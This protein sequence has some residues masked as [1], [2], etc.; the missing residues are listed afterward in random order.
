MS[1]E[2][3]TI[4]FRMYYVDALRDLDARAFADR[5]SGRALPD[6]A[7][8]EECS[9][10]CGPRHMLDRD[11]TLDNIACG[12]VIRL[13]FVTVVRK[14][15]ESLLLAECKMEEQ[16]TM[17]ASGLQVLPRVARAEIRQRV[18]ERLLPQTQAALSAI[19][20]WI[21]PAKGVMFAETTT[22]A[23][24]DTLCCAFKDAFGC[25]PIMVTPETAA[26]RMSGV[27]ANDLFPA[28]YSPDPAKDH[29]VEVFLGMEFLTW[30][31]WNYDQTGGAFTTRLHGPQLGYMLEGPITFFRIGQGA[32][33]VNIRKGNPI[34]S[35]EAKTCLL[36]GK[37]LKSAKFVLADGDSIFSARVDDSFLFS[38]LKLPPGER[39]DPCGRF[40]ER[41]LFLDRFLEAWLALYVKFIGERAD[42][43][44]WP[45]R[46][47]EIRGW[48]AACN[49]LNYPF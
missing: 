17:Q 42:G 45:V 49:G 28:L 19:A 26:F 44:A 14:V 18:R 31:F 2:T 21:E 35:R 5:L 13:Q 39:L 7:G 24:S 37:L 43:R 34:N 9:G 30:L 29:P 6:G 41:A 1:L 16:A 4:S 22:D 32:H 46:V 33:E 38:A 25:L 47:E 3:G 20:L 36:D 27:H 10:W 48:I 15:S 8:L 23:K 40:Q 11:L 12:G